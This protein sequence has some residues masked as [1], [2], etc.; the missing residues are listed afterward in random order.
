MINIKEFY[1]RDKDLEEE[2]ILENEMA[3][4]KMMDY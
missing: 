3:M 1:Y 4:N 2:L